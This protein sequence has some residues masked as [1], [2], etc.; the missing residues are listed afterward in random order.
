MRLPLPFSSISSRHAWR[1]AAGLA[2]GA[3]LCPLPLPA[4]SDLATW[5][6]R[7]SE[8]D[9]EALNA[10]GNAY[11]LGQGVPR[12]DNEAL[13]HYQAAANAGYAP[14]CFN[15]GLIHELGRGVPRNE[16]EAARWYRL[17]AAQNHPRAAL[18]L[19]VLLEDGRGV[20][21]DEAEAARLYRLA[22]EQGIGA[23]Q[24]S[25]GLMLAAGRGAL[26]VNLPEA[27][28]WLT[29]AVEQGAPPASRDLVVARLT[30]EQRSASE[31][32]LAELRGR[33]GAGAPVVPIAPAPAPMAVQASAPAVPPRAPD[34]ASVA[35]L[36]AELVQLRTENRE[37]TTALNEAGREVRRLEAAA[38]SARPAAAAAPLVDMAALTAAQTANT[39]LQSELTTLR[40]TLDQKLKVIE[41]LT[42]ELAL[43]KEASVQ[44]VSP[45]ESSAPA[46]TGVSE[47]TYDRMRADLE[48]L[49]GQVTVLT[50][51]LAVRTRERDEALAA[52]PTSNVSVSPTSS[53]DESLWVARLAEAN[54]IAASFQSQTA[55]LAA[56][57]VAL[58]DEVQRLRGEVAQLAA[59]VR[60]LRGDNARL[61]AQAGV[62]AATGAA[63]VVRVPPAPTPTV[64]FTP[65]RATPTR[66]GRLP[67]PAIAPTPSVPTERF[68]IVLHGDSLSALSLRYY[69]NARRW[70][71][72]FEANRDVLRTPNQLRPGQRLRIP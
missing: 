18:Q 69:G 37:L 12:D 58:N 46:S 15:L 3:A 63:P 48:A 30:P 29:L 60:V 7:A 72:I 32:I 20:T 35:D 65:G 19:A 25:L 24:T 41:E 14:A 5:R 44:A 56:V 13:R 33:L 22:A 57:N 66:P 6:V 52:R 53:P 11:A 16:T 34:G 42:D 27:A 36:K 38:A 40:A 71:T 45:T 39:A 28:A 49:R 64:A 10:L 59:S 70:N 26:A 51:L 2:A 54:Q 55:E 8:G 68:H 21:R 23:A 47:V 9:A 1:F 43:V 62:P 31:A 61:A 17:A 67:A 50:D 4:Q